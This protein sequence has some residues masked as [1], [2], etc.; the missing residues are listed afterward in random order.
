[1]RRTPAATPLSARI[2]KNPMSPVARDVRAAAQLHAEARHADDADLVAV[3]LA[4][5]RHRAGRDGLLGRH[6]DVRLHRRVP[7]DLLVDDALDAIELVARD[8]LEVHEV[9]AQAIGRDERAG[10]L[11]V[12]AEH[13]AQRGVEQV[14]R[15]VIAARRV[16]DVR[17][18]FGGDDVARAKL[19]ARPRGHDARAGSPCERVSGASSS[20]TASPLGAVDAAGVGHLSA[21]F[22][23]ERRL[24]QDDPARL[25]F[26]EHV[27]QRRLLVVQ[28]RQSARPPWSWSS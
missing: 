19:P 8:R 23:V 5:Q 26:A 27:G 11:D 21:R 2:A 16:A 12:R 9:E 17:V 28:D 14:R 25:A 20:T 15:R 4:E 7:V 1:M 6:V 22:E 10:L 13:L 3:F 24:R 18:H